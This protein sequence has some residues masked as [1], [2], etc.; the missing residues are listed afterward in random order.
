MTTNSSE[1]TLREDILRPLETTTDSSETTLREDILRPLET[2]TDSS[3]TTLREDIR[4]GY[5][6]DEGVDAV[7]YEPVAWRSRERRAERVL[8]GG[9]VG[10][11]AG[12]VGVLPGVGEMRG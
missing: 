10:R 3:E 5:E 1:T 11:D 7:Q 4:T 12:S 2:T 8:G 6:L 9:R